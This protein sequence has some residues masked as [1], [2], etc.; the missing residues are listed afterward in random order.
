M[1]IKNKTLEKC[2]EVRKHT[3]TDLFLS[4]RGKE[5]IIFHASNDVKPHPLRSKYNFYVFRFFEKITNVKSCFFQD[6]QSNGTS[7][8]YRRPGTVC[9]QEINVCKIFPVT[10][11]LPPHIW[12]I[13]EPKFS[14]WP[15]PIEE[16]GITSDTF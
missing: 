5:I 1:Q 2:F 7:Q 12:N 15:D 11:K 14:P 4:L 8:I 10:E 9:Q 3:Y 16:N 13:I 6:L